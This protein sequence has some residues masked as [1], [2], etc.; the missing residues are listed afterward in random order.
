VQV[1]ISSHGA[2]GCNMSLELHFLFSHLDF[3]PDKATAI[4]SE[5]VETFHQDISQID[6]R[7]SGKWIP[8]ML[9]SDEGDTN[10]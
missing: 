10:W 2:V 8:N 6:K 3:F 7:N 4:C 1:L 5:H 9:D